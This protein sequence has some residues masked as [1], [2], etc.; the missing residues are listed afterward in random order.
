MIL[1]FDT[2]GPVC[3]LA[4]VGLDGYVYQDMRSE[5]LISHA[6]ELPVLTLKALELAGGIEVVKAIAVSKGPGSYTGLRIGTSLAKGLCYS[7]GIPLIS[8][9]PLRAIAVAGFSAVQAETC[10]AI[11]DAR[12]SEVYTRTFGADLQPLNEIHAHIVSENSFLQPNNSLVIAGN[13]TAKVENIIGER[14]DVSFVETESFAVNMASEV[15]QKFH[16][17]EFESVAYYEPFYLKDFI[18]GG[19]TK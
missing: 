12:R 15:L 13:C 19:G 16:S 3:S 17:Q 11:I 9:C 4:V 18:A 6:E 7:A 1:I 2:S 5:K 10:T 14:N 8:A